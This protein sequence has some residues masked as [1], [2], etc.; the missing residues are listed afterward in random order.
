MSMTRWKQLIGVDWQAPVNP[1]KLRI[2][3]LKEIA[4][5]PPVTWL[6][7][8]LIPKQSLAM[9]YGEPGG[10]KT[11]TALDIALTV[12]HGAQWHGHEVAQGQVF[13]VAGEG[14]GGFRKRI[15]AWHQHQHGA[16]TLVLGYCERRF[17]CL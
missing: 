12:A 10:G 7:N 3:T 14:V 15:G 11:F 2:L 5:L 16:Q 1:P 9:I 8:G 4:E 6:V 17:F 13:Y